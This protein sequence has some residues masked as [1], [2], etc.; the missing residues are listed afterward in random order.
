LF[1]LALA[2]FLLRR[3]WARQIH[4]QLKRQPFFVSDVMPEDVVQTIAGLQSAS[5]KAMPTLGAQLDEDITAGH[6]VLESDPFWTT[7]LMFRQMPPH[8]REQL[9][10]SALMLVKGDVNYR[11]LLDDR[12]WPYTTRMEDITGYF[13]APFVTL[14]TLKGEILVGLPPGRAETLQAEDPGWL[15][16]GKRGVIQLVAAQSRD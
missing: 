15:I 6:L 2:D 3:G 5:G 12:H 7:C 11:R 1:D 14:R 16:N 4:L 10:Q 13:P 9:S 8:L